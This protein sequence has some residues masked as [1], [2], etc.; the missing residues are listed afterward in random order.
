MH[1]RLPSCPRERLRPARPARTKVNFRRFEHRYPDSI[2]NL[3]TRATTILSKN[4]SC[5]SHRRLQHLAESARLVSK[6]CKVLLTQRT[7]AVVCVTEV[8]FASVYT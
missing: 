2:F 8:S 7:V 1:I 6:T 4:T 3:A 5:R